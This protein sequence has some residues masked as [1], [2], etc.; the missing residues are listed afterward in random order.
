MYS[1]YLQQLQ[2]PQQLAQLRALAL[3]HFP[4]RP[5]LPHTHPS[6]H[7][8]V[9]GTLGSMDPLNRR[10][11]AALSINATYNRLMQ[12]LIV[13]DVI[14]WARDIHTEHVSGVRQYV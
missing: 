14:K 3:T 10:A 2:P 12:R 1:C 11:V 9:V 5:P 6:T 13:S 7:A 4:T 8:Y